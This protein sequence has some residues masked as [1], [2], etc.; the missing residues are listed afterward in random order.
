MRVAPS[1]LEKETIVKASA[2]GNSSKSEPTSFVTDL[3]LF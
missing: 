3:E 1:A 2:I